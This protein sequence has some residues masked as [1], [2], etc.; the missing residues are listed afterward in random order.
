MVSKQEKVKL[1]TVINQVRGISY[2]EHDLAKEQSENY[3]PVLRANNINDGKLDFKDLVFVNKARIKDIQMIKEGDIIVAASSGSLSVVGKAAQ[4]RNDIGMSFGAFCK[5]I[6]PSDKVDAKYIG[7]YFQSPKYRRTISSLANGANINNIKNE[8][9]DELVI[10]LPPLETQKKIVEALD[11]A[12]ALIDAR[13]E[14]IRLMDELVKSRF[15]E[16]FGDPILNNKNFEV[17]LGENVYKLSNG[18]TVPTEK[19]NNSGIPAYG[20]NGIS[21][22]TDEVLFDEDTV[23]VGRVGFQ[24]GNVHFVKGPLWITD[25]AMYISE[26]FDDEYKL[27]FLYALMEHIDFSR[28]Q[29]AG[30]LKKVTQK[31]FMEMKYIKPPIAL[32]EEYL[33]FCDQVDKLTLDVQKNFD[34]LNKLYNS[35]QQSYFD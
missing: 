27:E 29:D 35:I 28:F 30:D 34:H 24:S 31:P 25:N 22:Y 4:A 32:Q 21:W 15:V 6:R 26:L 14:Q 18:K 12:Q 19:R 1:G 9:I 5:L 11:K 2:K 20:G 13:K 33:Q 8:H 10:Q 7:Y 3:I 17:K 23:V 16:M